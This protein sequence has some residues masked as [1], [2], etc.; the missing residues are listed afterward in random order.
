VPIGGI[1]AAQQEFAAVAMLFKEAKMM[2]L[3][4]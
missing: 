4:L 1:D 2:L 3:I